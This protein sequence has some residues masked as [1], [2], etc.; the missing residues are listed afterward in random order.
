MPEE[1]ICIG[2]WKQGKPCLFSPEQIHPLPLDPEEV[3]FLKK[4]DGCTPVEPSPLSDRMEVMRI[5]HRCE[6][7]ENPVPPIPIN[8]YPNYYVQCIDWTITDR[9]NYNCRH[10]FHATDNTVHRNEFTLEQAML[11]LDEVRDCGIRSVNL[12]GGEPT[13]YPWFREVV[14]GM[15]E[16]G[17]AL[18]TL[19]TNG[20]LLTP[21][22]LD[23]LKKQHP[24]TLIRISFD[25]IGWHDWMRQH[26]GSEERTIEAIRLCRDAG[27][28]VHI[29]AN[30]HRK[31]ESVMFD[32][33][34]MLAELTN[35]VPMIKK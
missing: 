21:E 8:H 2:I 26:E 18:Q 7:H 24:Q 4:C 30:V 11:F 16:R 35:L 34:K 28:D 13:L 5:I 14:E 32:S 1:D 31:N 15:R 27:L 25:G 19:V 29:N 10:C 12:T 17:I 6:K 33:L 20:S 22:L 23:F 3:T 9:C